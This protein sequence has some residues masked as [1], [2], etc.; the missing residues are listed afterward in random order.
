M[1]T[2]IKGLITSPIVTTHEPLSRVCA[3][4]MEDAT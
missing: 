3:T 1:I 4:G 2:H